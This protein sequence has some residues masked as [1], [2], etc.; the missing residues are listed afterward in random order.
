MMAIGL[1]DVL[2]M[3]YFCSANLFFSNIIHKRYP[4]TTQNSF[5]ILNI[6]F[7]NIIFASIVVCK[8]ANIITSY[9]FVLPWSIFLGNNFIFCYLCKDQLRSSL[10][11]D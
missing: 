8:I 5:Q 6:E 11:Y 3:I 9:L 1:C 4:L 7:N 2:F 10:H